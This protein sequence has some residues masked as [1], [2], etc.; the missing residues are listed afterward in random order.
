MA[1]THLFFT[2]IFSELESDKE[3]DE[4]RLVSDF[5][6]PEDFEKEL[7]EMLAQLPRNGR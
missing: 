4:T 1:L 2:L 6:S 5:S 7:D 3:S